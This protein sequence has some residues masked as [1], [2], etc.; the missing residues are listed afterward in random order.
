MNLCNVYSFSDI[1][2]TEAGK[3]SRNVA[4]GQQHSVTTEVDCPAVSSGP[5]PTKLP[6]LLAKYAR[7]PVMSAASA[8]SSTTPLS[9]YHKYLTLCTDQLQT[10]DED[11]QDCLQFW[12]KRKK[13]LPTLFQVAMKVHSVPAT[14]APIERVFSHGGIV[15]RPHRARMGHNTLSNIVFLKCNVE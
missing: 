3:V 2:V 12:Q 15:M 4:L 9:E 13:D 7:P 10:D 1:V 11:M 6:K 8:T 14:S 5:P